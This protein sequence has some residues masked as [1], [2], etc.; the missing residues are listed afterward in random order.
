MPSSGARSK[1]NGWGRPSGRSFPQ[2]YLARYGE[3]MSKLTIQAKDKKAGMSLDE[4]IDV[5]IAAKLQGMAIVGR[6]RVGFKGQ[7][8]EM[9]FHKPEE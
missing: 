9:T 7:I 2:S 3:G 1:L 8:L 5:V 4:I 6:T